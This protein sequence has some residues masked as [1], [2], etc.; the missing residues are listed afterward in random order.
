M[1]YV[2]R[3]L[4]FETKAD[5][6]EYCRLLDYDPNISKYVCTLCGR[7]FKTLTGPRTDYPPAYRDCHDSDHK[8][9]TDFPQ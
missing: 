8:L 6:G 4:E 7:Q 2:P 5:L 9:C 1:K 3:K